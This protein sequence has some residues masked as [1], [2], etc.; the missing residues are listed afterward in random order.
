MK[1]PAGA[2]AIFCTALILGAFLN[3]ACP[4]RGTDSAAEILLPAAFGDGWVV[5][6]KAATYTANTLYK[7]I[8]G[9]AELYVPYGLDRAAAARYVKPGGGSADVVVNVFRMGSPLDA[10]GI[11]GNYRSPAY[12]EVDLG[13]QGFITEAQL[14]FY[15]DR[16]FVQVEASGSSSQDP[17]VFRRCAEAVARTLPANRKKPDEIALLAVRGLVPFS[18]RYYPSGLLGYGF[19]GRGLTAE[20]LV[21]GVVV[22]PFVALP[23]SEQAA[24]RTFSEYVR[25]LRESGGIRDGDGDVK[26]PGGYAVDPLYKGVAFEQS[27]PYVVGVAGLKNPHDGEELV[28]ELVGRLPSSPR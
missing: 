9:E 12:T 26:K 22:K 14:M 19:L 24:Q 6:G 16:Y 28:I 21:K 10:F 4:A 17:Q 11:Y 5:E 3:T 27:G 8:D 1:R 15:Q 25:Y 23:G 18:E 20:V 7:Y 2:Y 13:T